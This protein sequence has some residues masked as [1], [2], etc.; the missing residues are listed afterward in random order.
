MTSISLYVSFIVSDRSRND[1]NPYFFGY[2]DK[3]FKKQKE[4]DNKYL[5]QKGY[6]SA[7]PD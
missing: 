1:W 4:T 7:E 3:I 2:Y 6:K 5:V